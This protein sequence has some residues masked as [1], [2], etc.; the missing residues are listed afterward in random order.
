M[1]RNHVLRHT[2]IGMDMEDAIEVIEN[3]VRW[4]SPSINRYDGFSHP[5]LFVDGP[6]GSPTA[7]I[8]GDQS[9]QT[10]PEIYDVPLFHNRAVR[11][12]WGFDENGKLIDVF[13]RSGFRFRI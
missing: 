6:D 2:P 10:W 4:G 8:I 3:R 5:R 7:S 1:I 13:V 9:I 11:I 12:S